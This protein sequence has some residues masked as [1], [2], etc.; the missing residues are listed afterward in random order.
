MICA[1]PRS[2]IRQTSLNKPGLQGTMHPRRRIGQQLITFLCFTTDAFMGRQIQSG[3]AVCRYRL[4]KDREVLK[5]L[6]HSACEG[7]G[8]FSFCPVWVETLRYK[9][10]REDLLLVLSGILVSDSNQAT[11]PQRRGGN[12]NNRFSSRQAVSQSLTALISSSS[13]F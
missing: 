5:H 13:V 3:R 4:A 2:V 1:Q 10:I 11:A 8:G 9:S 12:S 7:P 6:E